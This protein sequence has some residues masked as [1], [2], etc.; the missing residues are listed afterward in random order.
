[1]CPATR[2]IVGT[3][4]GTVAL[5]ACAPPEV[6]DPCAGS[7]VTCGASDLGLECRDGRLEELCE[8]CRGPDDGFLT[9]I[10]KNV[11]VGATECQDGERTSLSVRCKDCEGKLGCEPQCTGVRIQ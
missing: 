5:I 7:F 10:A 4:F 2:L 6:G 9:C 8:D 1:M 3:I 11:C